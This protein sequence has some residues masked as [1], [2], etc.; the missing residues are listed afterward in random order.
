M[1]FWGIYEYKIVYNGSTGGS[2]KFVGTL[3]LYSKRRK[4]L[5]TK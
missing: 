5:I 4:K 1:H 3:K 2:E